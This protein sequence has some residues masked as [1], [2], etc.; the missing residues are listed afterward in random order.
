MPGILEGLNDLVRTMS[1]MSP[2][3]MY[4]ALVAITYLENVFPPVPGD[5]VVVFGGYMA[6]LGELGFVQV[7]VAGTLGGTAGFMTAYGIGFWM[8]DGVLRRLY[9]VPAERVRT[10]RRWLERYGYG[11]VTVNRF[12]SVLRAAISVTVGM[13]RLPADRVA[14]F[15]TVG[16]VLWCSLL[17]YL[18]YV[19]G[20]N[21]R[22]VGLYLSRYG[23]V[24]LGLFG[25]YVMF[26]VYK[27]IRSG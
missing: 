2:M 5:M 17:V 26:N 19:V 27:Y 16:G 9:W 15:A 22:V 6:G 11:L 8:G 12:L 1:E 14:F 7:V 23:W 20:E 10:A 24:V 4:G 21:W 25:S 18:G 13:A 3:W